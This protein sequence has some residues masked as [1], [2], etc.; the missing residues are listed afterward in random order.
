[1]DYCSTK[2]NMNKA[3][4]LSDE[5]TKNIR[6]IMLR[7]PNV[8]NKH[9]IYLFVMACEKIEKICSDAFNDAERLGIRDVFSCWRKLLIPFWK[10]GGVWE[11]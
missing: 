11:Y 8:L 2:D 4:M 1:M 6:S 5:V 3:E 7:L 9:N 10:F